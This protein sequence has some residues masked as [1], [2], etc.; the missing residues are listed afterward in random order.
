MSGEGSR[1]GQVRQVLRLLPELL[2]PAYEVGFGE[3]WAVGGRFIKMFRFGS[4]R[5]RG[6]E[7]IVRRDDA[8]PCNRDG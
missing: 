5:D 2:G 8:L 1:E 4:G 7:G 3:G 6:S